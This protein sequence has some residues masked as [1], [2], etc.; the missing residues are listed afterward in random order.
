MPSTAGP[1]YL[2][3]RLDMDIDVRNEGTADAVATN[4]QFG[5]DVNEGQSV[6]QPARLSAL[7]PTSTMLPGADVPI[8][9]PA[10]I[11]FVPF[12]PAEQGNYYFWLH[13][14]SRNGLL[15]VIPGA[16]HFT[17]ARRPIQR[18]ASRGKRR[19]RTS[20]G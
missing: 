18:R 17:G 1:L 14:A 3:D 6:I 9:L 20:P 15:A 11:P 12:S 8:A 16:R 13:R 10:E 2:R 5:F 4:V 7:L 19:R